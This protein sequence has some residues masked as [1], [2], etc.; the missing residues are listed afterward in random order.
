MFP[1]EEDSEILGAP[2]VFAMAFE[3][4]NRWTVYLLDNV[5]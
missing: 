1:H 3:E 5:R 2:G 4:E